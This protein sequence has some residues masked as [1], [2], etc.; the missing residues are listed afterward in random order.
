MTQDQVLILALKV[1]CIIGVIG[2]VQW[3]IVYSILERWWRHQLGWSLVAKTI[4]IAGL[5]SLTLISVFFHVNRYN[6]RVILWLD[7]ILIFL[8]A[9]V[10]IWRSIVWI[11]SSNMNG[12]GKNKG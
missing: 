10:M 7:I 4:L 6:S 1:S 12:N 2:L 9:P 8:I 11:K 3:V 5:L